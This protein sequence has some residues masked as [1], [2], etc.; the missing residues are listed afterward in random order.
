LIYNRVAA[1]I[2]NS[3]KVRRAIGGISGMYGDMKGILGRSSPRPENIEM[4]ALAPALPEY[5]GGMW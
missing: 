5:P 2:K 4:K 3:K 1:N